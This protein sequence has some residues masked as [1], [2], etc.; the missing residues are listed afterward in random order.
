MEPE[1]DS[2]KSRHKRGIKKQR[3]GELSQR[4]RFQQKNIKNSFVEKLHGSIDKTLFIYWRVK[5]GQRWKTPLF[6]LILTYWRWW[7]AVWGGYES[8]KEKKKLPLHRF[9]LLREY[10]PFIAASSNA[11]E[12]PV[13]VRAVTWGLCCADGKV[14][15]GVT[16]KSCVIFTRAGKYLF[17]SQIIECEEAGYRTGSTELS[18]SRQKIRWS[19]T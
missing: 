11:S 16:F 5:C 7:K 14:E 9:F 15:Q 3:K 10:Y 13:F 19:A 2:F 12:S 18:P 1:G 6:P 4:W 17:Y 8:Q